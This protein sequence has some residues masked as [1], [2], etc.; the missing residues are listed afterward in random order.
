MIKSTKI[1]IPIS[2]G[3]VP[4]YSSKYTYGSDFDSVRF[5]IYGSYLNQ[6]MFKSY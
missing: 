3:S 5:L 4:V 6:T 2:I 1:M